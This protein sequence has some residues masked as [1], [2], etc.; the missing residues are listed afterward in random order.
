MYTMKSGNFY[1][2][3]A[4]FKSRYKTALFWASTL[5]VLYIISQYKFNLFH[6]IVDGVSIVIAVCIFTIIWNSRRF[7]DNNYFLF[8][9]IA[10]L[11]FGLLDLIHL[12]GNKG[13]GVFPEYGNL[14]PT[15]YIASR[16]LL[17]ISMLLAPLF[18]RRRL[19]TTLLFSAY[20][21]ITL[22]VLLSIF[23]WQ[24]F[25]PTI[26]E[27]VGLTP[28]KIISDYIICLIF[29][30]AI[31]TLLR[32]RESFDSGVLR[33][34]VFSIILSIA[35]GLTFALYTDPF[36]LTNVLGHFFQI[37]SFYLAYIAFIE[38]SVT[39]PQKT[40]YRKLKNNEE[41]L[42]ESNVEL[43]REISERKR[44]ED[45]LRDS[46]EQL[47]LFV[48]R[49]PA[50][51]AMFDR[52]MHYLKAS[53]RWLDDYN[54]G[55]RD[56]RGMSH[57]EIF[58]E[59]PEEWKEAHRAGIAGKVLRADADRFVRADGSEQWVRWEILPWYNYAGEVGGIVIFTEDI[60]ERK[61][62]EA[63]LQTL[64][65]R[66]HNI[67]SGM[68]AAVL[69]VGN[70]NMVEFSND[71]F[72]MMYELTE[73][74]A[75]L[76][77][78]TAGQ[79]LEKIKNVYQEP[80]KALKRIREIVSLGQPV[81]GEEIA[82]A[83]GRVLLRDFIPIMIDEKLYGM[84]WH[85]ID[86]TDLKRV[87]RALE[88]SEQRFRLALRN[89]P[90]SV[91]VQDRNLRYIWAYNQ[92]TAS[93]ERIIGKLDEDIFTPEE[94]A[95]IRP[96]TKRVLE[97][98]VELHDQMWFERPD[99]R[100]FLDIYW[101]PMH[102]DKGQVIGVGSTTV[103]LTSLKLVEEKLRHSEERY[104]I[105]H[106]TMRDAFVQVSMDGRIIEFNDSYCQMLGYSPQEMRS[107]TYKE[108][109]PE[110]W[111]GFEEEIVRSQIIPRGY[112]NVYEKEFLR[113]DGTI[114]P[115]ELRTVLS[116]D[117]SGRPNAMWAIVR[118]ISE[119]KQAEKALKTRTEELEDA[120]K[121]LES[122]SYSVSH[123]LRTP[124]RAIDGFSK[125]VLGDL[126]ASIDQE[127]KRKLNV[128]RANTE[129]MNQLIDALLNLSRL[130]RQAL[131]PVPLD[132]KKLFREAWDE[133]YQSNP[134]RN[135]RLVLEEL[136]QAVGDRTLIKQ[137]TLNLLS[138]AVKYSRNRDPVA[139]EIKSA[140][141]GDST[142]FSVKDNGAGF[143][144]RYYDK[145]FGVF[146]RLHTEREFE[147]TGVGLAVVKRIIHRH[148]GQ[149]WAEGEVGKGATFY[150]SLP[151]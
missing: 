90:V 74:P 15:F 108:L 45:A 141:N 99:G 145:L 27:G 56:L 77:G 104:R 114:I 52:D 49:A 92:R 44:F 142:V 140:R 102:D 7:L 26:I 59:I 106:E 68:Y 73:S 112:S 130:G 8:M 70:D 110:R 24:N 11:F 35:T 113:K 109:T 118:E 64:T 119:R 23:H 2:I 40:L 66:F 148:G 31:A 61:Q 150:F 50:A 78:L 100:I 125:M 63:A 28:F 34:I 37:G 144:M 91:A 36:G 111:H 72:C 21:I 22:L 128:I 123:D 107:L 9:S 10:F 65:K 18:I 75:E 41:A 132:M 115:V 58:P 55:Y 42:T 16:Y 137:V 126:E 30:G 134:D 135:V 12:L 51:L 89:A 136:D 97:E 20:S 133:I 101:E 124:L 127:S 67:L 43:R 129:K 151:A 86:I 1:S 95:R 85:H 38:T 46:E 116:R 3:K 79:M 32:N 83:D 143:D 54:L 19:N 120:N 139:I 5:P 149:V 76:R 84:L 60:T 147:G 13:M 98:D 33:L 131:K 29:A 96:L 146:H 47:Q 17:S 88:E 87:E 62:A 53:R 57:Y 6:S 94:I 82:M 105:L 48:E 25:P 103:N 117:E 93:P 81:R 80:E 121:E 122:F 39:K 14:G 71:A 138:N 69:L 4:Q